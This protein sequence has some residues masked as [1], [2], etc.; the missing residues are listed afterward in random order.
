MLTLLIE[1]ARATKGPRHVRHPTLEEITRNL[2]PGP[3]GWCGKPRKSQI[4][5]RNKDLKDKEVNEEKMVNLDHKDLK[6]H[7]VQEV[8][9]DL[10]AHKDRLDL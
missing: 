4:F 5:S 9:P 6:V 8:N 3:R 10:Q 1:S 2:Q 7:L